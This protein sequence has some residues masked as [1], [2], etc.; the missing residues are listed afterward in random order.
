MTPE[1]LR[2][3]VALVELAAQVAP[4]IVDAIK[5]HGELSDEQK[6]DLIARVNATR[7]AVRDY[8]PTP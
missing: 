8:Q 6:T 1:V 4:H 3:L 7:A 5:A 2:A